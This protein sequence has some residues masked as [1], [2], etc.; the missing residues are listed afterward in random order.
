MKIECPNCKE[1]LE[2]TFEEIEPSPNTK[3]VES[4]NYTDVID[5]ICAKA[6]SIAC[7]LN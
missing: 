7:I 6:W 3:E 4:N 1:A 2:I 5:S